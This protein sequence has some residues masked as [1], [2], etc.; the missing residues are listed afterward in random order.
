VWSGI[1][2]RT[3]DEQ[4]QRIGRQVAGYR[5]GRYFRPVDDSE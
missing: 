4:G 1:H 5:Q 2:F 3:A